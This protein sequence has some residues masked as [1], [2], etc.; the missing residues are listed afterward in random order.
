[1]MIEKHPIALQQYNRKLELPIYLEIQSQCRS[2]ILS[3]C[4]ELYPES[5]SKDDEHGLLPL[6]MLL[7]HE[8]S[9]TEDALLM[10]EKYPAAL[11]HCD[12]HS[13]FPIHFECNYQCRASIISKCIELYPE[14]LNDSII[15][16]IIKKINKCNLN[17][18]SSALSIVFTARPMGLYIDD[19]C[20]KDDIRKQPYFR[21]RIL[22]LLP[23]HVFT[24]THDADYRHLNWQPR[25]A[26]IMLL[27]QMKIQQKGSLSNRNRN[28]SAL[29]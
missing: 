20:T 6:H 10:I 28:A 21:R 7:R 11:K 26:M 5:L 17:I 9:H 12:K 25:V 8:S 16:I 14:S 23:H 29:A 15:V 27:S 19:S 22:H 2:S 1:M 18:L 13:H 3:R 4:I 24:P